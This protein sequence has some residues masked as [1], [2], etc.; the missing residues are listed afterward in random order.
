MYTFELQFFLLNILLLIG[1]LS[2]AGQEFSY[3]YNNIMCK[4]IVTKIA[5][6][7]KEDSVFQEK[8]A[9]LGARLKNKN[10]GR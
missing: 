10:K 9:Y 7:N 5:K 8:K 3:M 6:N 2:I 1:S 4:N